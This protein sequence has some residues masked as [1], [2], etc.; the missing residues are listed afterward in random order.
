LGHIFFARQKYRES[1]DQF[2]AAVRVWQRLG[3]MP[4]LV[5]YTDALV[6]L[7]KVMCGQRT[8]EPEFLFKVASENKLPFREGSIWR[9]TGMTLSQCEDGTM[10]K[11]Q[12]ALEN[13][14]EADTRNGTRWSLAMDY[15]AYAD[16]LERGQTGTEVRDKLGKALEVFKECGANGW[17]E[18]VE[19]RL[20]A[21]PQY[22]SG[23]EEVRLGVVP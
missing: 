1:M 12:I 10:E 21:R 19:R 6:L 9:C 13:A 3:I 17:S 8:P 16:L 2:A 11:A 23:P 4:S 7:A 18:E 14:I 15:L 5:G 20:T 22:I